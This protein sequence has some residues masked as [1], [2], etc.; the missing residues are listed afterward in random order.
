[1]RGLMSLL[2]IVI[3]VPALAAGPTGLLNDTGQTSCYDASN[4]AVACSSTGVGSDSGANP[5]Q[6]ARFGRDA[7]SGLTKIGGGAAGF[8][9]TALDASG[10]A[11]TPG[12][13]ACVK[14]NVTNLIWSTETL[15]DKTWSAAATAAASYSRCG[16]SSGWRVPTRRELTSIVHRGTSQPA[17]DSAY[18]PNTVSWYYWSSDNYKGD[19]A[20][21]WLVGFEFGE[22]TAYIAGWLFTPSPFVRLVRSGQ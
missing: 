5:R 3:A 8:D 11:T 14:D 6:D 16:F 7:K 10:N 20:S 18:F 15:S 1:M 2:V 13:H 21:V 17:I 9:F 4:N 22:I 12:S 19:P